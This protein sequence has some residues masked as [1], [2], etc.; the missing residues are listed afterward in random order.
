MALTSSTQDLIF[1]FWGLEGE[2]QIDVDAKRDAV[3][4]SFALGYA[5]L[6]DPEATPAEVVTAIQL[7]LDHWIADNAR[8]YDARA[9]AQ[10]AAEASR[11]EFNDETGVDIP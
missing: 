8:E 7:Y 10:A 6:T 9:A 4:L 1:T 11:G 5:R 2:A 3:L